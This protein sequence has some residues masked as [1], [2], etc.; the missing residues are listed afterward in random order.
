MLR[1]I[2][3]YLDDVVSPYW[4]FLLYLLLGL[5]M[6]T[7]LIVIFFCDKSLADK[8]SSFGSF[9]GLFVAT[10]AFIYARREYLRQR[11]LNERIGMQTASLPKLRNYLASNFVMIASN[12][13][14]VTT[15]FK[16]E[17]GK[18]S[19]GLNELDELEKSE[20]RFENDRLEK[21]LD[22]IWQE[23]VAQ[24]E[25]AFFHEAKFKSSFAD[26]NKE[27]ENLISSLQEVLF[28][29][30][31]KLKKLKYRSNQTELLA[32]RLIEN[33]YYKLFIEDKFNVWSQLDKSDYDTLQINLRT[34]VND[35]IEA[36]K[37]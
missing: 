25:K 18:L 24:R 31:F 7:G 10:A 28:L 27:L 17:N 9:A 5:F 30:T 19:G 4:E 23:F 26:K 33:T 14:S 21:E 12:Y 16:D 22:E 6:V 34:I 29:I 15:G 11:G 20:I 32:E 36:L 13:H 3:K 37:F 1:K 35:V 2:D 8:F